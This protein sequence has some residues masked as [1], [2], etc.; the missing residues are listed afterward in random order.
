MP[1]KFP[2]VR[3]EWSRK[4]R[5]SHD[6]RGVTTHPD[7]MAGLHEHEW[8]ITLIW[9]AEYNCAIGFQRDEHAIE[10]SWGDH[11]DKLNGKNLSE[12]MPLPATSENLACWL[13]LD[14][15]TRPSDQEVSY[16]LSG[17]RVTKDG[18]SAEVMRTEANRRAWRWFCGE[19]A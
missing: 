14:Y 11:L 9:V 17:L 19:M 5:A 6:L 15:C 12:L 2:V 18:H 3:K 1:V 16:E 7:A 8:T 13:L 10:Q 4:I